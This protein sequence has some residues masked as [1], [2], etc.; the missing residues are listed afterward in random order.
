VQRG[1]TSVINWWLPLGVSVR[2]HT[3]TVLHYLG[4]YCSL[5]VYPWQGRKKVACTFFGSGSFLDRARP[6]AHFFL[7]TLAFLCSCGAKQD[8]DPCLGVFLKVN[9]G[10]NRQGAGLF[11]GVVGSVSF[12]HEKRY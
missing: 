4:N 11:G 1:G 6:K 2:T 8:R 3:F 12:A 9:P 10:K 5:Y 7:S